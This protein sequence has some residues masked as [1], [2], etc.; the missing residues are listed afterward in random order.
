M[1]NR[2]LRAVAGANDDAEVSFPALLTK[3]R[4]EIERALPRHI[5][6]DRICRIALTAFRE[7]PAL[8]KCSPVSIFASV[9]KASQLGLEV[10]L[11][12]RAFLVPYGEECQF[13]PGWKGLVELANRS[14]RTS[15]WT[16]AV[17]QGDSFEYQL[18]DSP[19]LRHIPGDEDDPAKLTHV[20][21]IG[22]IKGSE[23]PVIEVWTTAKVRKHRDRYNRVGKRHY[24]YDNW[25]MYARKVPLLQVL[26]YVPSSPEMDVAIALN[27][28]AESG[29]QGLTID[30]ALGDYV[31]P[32][33]TEGAQNEATSSTENL[34]QPAGDAGRRPD[35]SVETQPPSPPAQPAPQSEPHDSGLEPAPNK[36]LS[37]RQEIVAM[38][39][40]IKSSEQCEHQM[41]QIMD[42]I[43]HIKD[44]PERKELYAMASRTALRF[45]RGDQE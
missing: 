1:S 2:E 40:G 5:T 27:D 25:E 21:A 26:K 24:S 4:G 42:R 34:V 20:Y 15:V 3:Y 37:P 10:G 39:E 12:G 38:L 45:G 44:V 9:L 29:R 19:F 17:F 35:R 33:H 31:P 28:A 30:A 22:R 32:I 7:N 6:A 13:I 18:G 36:S 16:G 14:G 8:R 43:R 11:N 41:P 23:W